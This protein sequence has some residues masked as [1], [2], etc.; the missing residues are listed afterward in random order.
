MGTVRGSCVSSG[1]LC[2]FTFVSYVHPMH[3][4]MFSLNL[5]MHDS[6]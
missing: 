6:T 1:V 4:H 5:H 3:D 2:L